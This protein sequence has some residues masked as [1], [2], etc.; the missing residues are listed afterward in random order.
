[1][2]TKITLTTLATRLMA[3]HIRLPGCPQVVCTRAFA[4]RWL[5]DAGHDPRERG[6]GSIDYMVFSSPAVDEP[7]NTEEY[8]EFLRQVQEHCVKIAQR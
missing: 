1:M 2:K 8:A 3:E 6:F 4:M 5:L 7:E